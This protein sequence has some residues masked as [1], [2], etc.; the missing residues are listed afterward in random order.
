MT[1]EEKAFS[2]MREE[3]KYADSEH[4]ITRTARRLHSITAHLC[5]NLM[6]WLR[7]R[8]SK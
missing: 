7:K 5:S 6:N 8:I 4:V 2:I 1:L 3:L